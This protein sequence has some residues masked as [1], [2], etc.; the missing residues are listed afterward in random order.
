MSNILEVKQLCKY[1]ALGRRNYLKAVENVSFSIEK[2]EVFG[3]VGES[4][5]GKTTCGKT[6]IGMLNPTAGEVL[7]KGRSIHGL[8]RREYRAYTREVQMIFQ[9]PYT[10]LDP[11][12]KVYDIIAEGL[13]IHKLTKDRE[14]ERIKVMELMEA[15]NL[16]PGYTGRYIHEF[17]GGQRQRIGIARALSLEPE[18]IFCDEPISALDVSVQ[19]QII[20]LMKELQEKRRLTLMFIAHD[21]SMV[22]YISDRI[23]VMYLGNIVEMG[24][25]DEICFGAIHPYTK[26]L[27]ASVPEPDP[28][29][30][31]NVKLTDMAEIEKREEGCCFYGRCKYAVE[32]CRKVKPILQE[33]NAGHYAACHLYTGGK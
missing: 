9:D 30:K 7:Y 29:K 3:V 25:A 19:A 33:Y 28:L 31:V 11:R 8:S 23:A 10:S 17:S 32:K 5:C 14:E 18:F 21:L 20:N 12:L 24:E 13:R 2:G 26:M 16:A 4:G 6:C 1:Y 27:L 15:V 22:R